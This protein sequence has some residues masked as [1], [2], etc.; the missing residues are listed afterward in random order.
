MGTK[1]TWAPAQTAHEDERYAFNRAGDALGA[2]EGPRGARAI[3][4]ILRALLQ[5]SGKQPHVLAARL[6]KLEA[7]LCVEPGKR[8]V[9]GADEEE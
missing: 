7:R 9:K 6:R 5:W 2:I 8:P 4:G 1:K 3:D